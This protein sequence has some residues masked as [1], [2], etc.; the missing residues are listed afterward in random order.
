MR[1]LLILTAIAGAALLAPICQGGAF[2]T[3]A[4]SIFAEADSITHTYLYV[5]AGG[6]RT[7]RICVDPDF[8][9]IDRAEPAIERAVETWNG[10][11]A[12]TGNLDQGTVPSD[13]ADFETTALHELGH[14]ALGLGH[15][16]LGFRIS[17]PD[18][19]NIFFTN[20]EVGPNAAF[21]F[22]PSDVTPGSLDDSRGDDVNRMW[23][24]TFDNNPFVLA[25]PIDGA[26]YSNDLADL[27]VGSS[28]AAN[29]NRFVG[30]SLPNPV[31]D[32]EAVMTAVAFFGESRLELMAD[33]VAVAQFART[34]KDSVAGSTD[35]Y[36]VVLEYGG[37]SNDSAAC[38]V[39]F[40]T[41]PNL[42]F[43]AICDVSGISIGDNQ[44]RL[45]GDGIIR[46]ASPSDVSWFYGAEVFTDGFESGNTTAW[47]LP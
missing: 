3:T 25:G 5:G 23:F 43:P 17:Q 46:M 19:T 38:D 1:R 40:R 8:A 26:T 14:C 22:D 35:D 4:I 41:D 31:F 47:D 13:R 33:D 28:F 2:L 32:T 34:G 36:D 21:E 37:R 30:A 42:G 7:V 15:P 24:N 18:G 11:S 45:A 16:N 9:D 10:L 6:Q 27:P 20:S 39:I 12:E 44:F 29:A